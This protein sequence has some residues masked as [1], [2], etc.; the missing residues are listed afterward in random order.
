M[1]PDTAQLSAMAAATSGDITGTATGTELTEPS[2]KGLK[3]QTSSCWAQCRP[4]QSLSVKAVLFD[5]G[6]IEDWFLSRAKLTS[7]VHGDG[8]M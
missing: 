2:H 6:S 4:D 1:P 7:Q 8:Y 5:F 3:K